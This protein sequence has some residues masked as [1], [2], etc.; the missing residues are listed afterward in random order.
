M[1]GEGGDGGV[2]LPPLTDGM[3]ASGLIFEPRVFTPVVVL[4]AVA[5]VPNEVFDGTFAA[6][7]AGSFRNDT[8]DLVHGGTISVE[9]GRRWRG[10]EVG[11]EVGVAFDK[12]TKPIDGKGG[13]EAVQG[14]G[15]AK[16][17]SVSGGFDGKHLEWPQVFRRELGGVRQI[18][19]LGAEQNARA[20]FQCEGARRAGSSLAELSL[21]G[22]IASVAAAI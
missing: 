10:G 14:V 8:V 16:G 22:R 2:A 17:C 18:Q 5:H 1:A 7:R 12:G 6:V 4:R 9:E 20:R 13:V 11:R 15:E 19:V 3:G 21:A